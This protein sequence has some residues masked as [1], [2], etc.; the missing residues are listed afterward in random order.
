MWWTAP[1][2]KR[3]PD[4]RLGTQPRVGQAGEVCHL[5][6]VRITCV[7]IAAAVTTLAP[8]A[9]AQNQPPDSSPASPARDEGESAP[10]PAERTTPVE[11]SP[12]NPP[13]I[14]VRGLSWDMLGGG[15][16]E[17]TGILQAELG[18][19]ALPRVAYH[20]TIAPK[21]SVGGLFALD[22]AR[23]A[24]E[25][26]F[27]TSLVFTGVGRYSLLHTDRWSIGLR[28]EPGVRI[29]LD[30]PFLF[31]LL[32]NVQGHV[33]Y[34]IQP[35]LIIG[36]GMDIPMEV[37]IPSEGSAFFAAPLLFGGF[38]EFHVAPQLALTADVKMG[39]YLNT[40]RTVFGMRV[41]AG[42]AVRL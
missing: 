32:L 19:S 31:G 40:V 15:I 18:F 37:G 16:Q 9:L 34:A 1:N 35:H 26:A 29:G 6:L 22:Y 10:S 13:D 3:R 39:P 2:M 33:G 27:T 14:A 8:P 36:G 41:L 4:S 38:A 42:I 21:A 28:G 24:P 30:D 17:G 11:A 7:L 20:H 23:W 12:S 25:E 5:R